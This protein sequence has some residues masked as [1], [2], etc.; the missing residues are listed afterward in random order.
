LV[1]YFVAFVFLYFLCCF[2][3]SPA[4]MG[5]VPIWQT[6]IMASKYSFYLLVLFIREYYVNVNVQ[7]QTRTVFAVRG[8]L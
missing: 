3:W 8:Q 2:V 5:I 4:L 1:D 7:T 6:A